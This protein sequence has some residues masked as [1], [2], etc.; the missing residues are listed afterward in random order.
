M[1]LPSSC[2]N[3][4]DSSAIATSGFILS[5]TEVVVGG[6]GGGC[7]VVTFRMK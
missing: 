7:I 2:E 3:D 4:L 6:G 5:G 1:G